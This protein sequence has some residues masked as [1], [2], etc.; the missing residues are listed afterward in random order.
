MLTLLTIIK[1][2]FVNTIISRYVMIVMNDDLRLQYGKELLGI[3][4]FLLKN[5]SKFHCTFS[6]SK[7]L[8]DVLSK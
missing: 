4:L 2:N 8:I 7:F 3:H 1:T 6:I 5:G